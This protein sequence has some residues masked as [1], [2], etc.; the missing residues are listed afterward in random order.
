MDFQFYPTPADLAKRMW[1]KF[2]DRNYVRVLEPSA[3][4]GDL[5]EAGK[6]E[7]RWGREFAIDCCEIDAT[8]H[9]ALREKGLNVVGLD[10]MDLASAS[11]YSHIIANPPFQHGSAH[12]LRCWQLL[13][14]GEICAIVNAETVRNPFSQ[15]RRDLVKLIDQFGEVEFIENAFVVDDAE[16][17]T[18]V[19]VAL[20]WLR[21]T[22]DLQQDV[23]GNLFEELR[24][25]RSTPES[26]S[27]DFK[28]ESN[29]ALSNTVIENAVLAFDAAVKAMRDSVFSSARARYYSALLGDTMAVRN[30]GG[31]TTPAPAVDAV[32]KS[33]AEGYQ[34]LKDRAW[35]NVLRSTNVTD[36]LSSAAQ[37]RVESE[38]EQIKKLDF[39]VANIYGFLCG[40]IE[41][42]GEIQLQMA[43]D[44]FD[45]FTRY[46]S[47][48]TVFY[49]G[50]R[51]NDRHWTCGVRLKTTRMV[52]PG[53]RTESYN[54]GLP[55]ESERL[56]AD[57]DKVFAMLDGKLEPE[58]GLVAAFRQHF[59]A[60]RTGSRIETTYFDVRYYPGT[61]T[62]HFFAKSK[63][64]IDRLNRLVGR[65]RNWL[66]PESDRVS[67]N[68][69]LQYDQAE[70]FDKDLRGE[71]QKLTPRSHSWGYRGPLDYIMSTNDKE[72]QE[73]AEQLVDEALTTVLERHGISVEF[74]IAAQPQAQQALLLEAA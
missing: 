69:W 74:R 66:P 53:H 65:H 34:D 33:I 23:I 73:K 39:T 14:N 62:V 28:Q 46:H 31:A 35:T 10:F 42:Q 19:E 7:G 2:K 29:V 13:W 41:K 17:K 12:I 68:F 43:L 16:R 52:L 48:N 8:R 38:F 67:D 55:Y 27:A 22:A 54:N 3:G 72:A 1:A 63:V 45:L 21:K 60:L 58:F 37:K 15:E 40:L 61:G 57:F 26:L 30:G 20:I 24:E 64:L 50:W 36:R 47:D 51:S 49:K 18:N 70:K 4:N 9:G 44:V 5:A 59:H 6:P 11:I 56:L 32:Q 25:D 71:V